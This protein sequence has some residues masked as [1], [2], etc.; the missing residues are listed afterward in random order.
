MPTH[1]VTTSAGYIGELGYEYNLGGLS[2]TVPV[3]HGGIPG[4]MLQYRPLVLRVFVV[5]QKAYGLLQS[6]D[7]SPYTGATGD[8]LVGAVKVDGSNYQSMGYAVYKSL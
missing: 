5:T 8:P 6:T 2:H 7:M 1:T 4:Y 3:S